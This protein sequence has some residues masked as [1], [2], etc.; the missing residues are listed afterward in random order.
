[1]RKRYPKTSAEDIAK[2]IMEARPPTEPQKNEWAGGTSVG[3]VFYSSIQ[4]YIKRHW[5]KKYPHDIFSKVCDI[6]RNAGYW[7][8]S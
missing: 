1:M 3:D 4:S 5:G 2:E 7:V 8:H 6:L